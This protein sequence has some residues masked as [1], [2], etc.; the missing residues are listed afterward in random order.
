MAATELKRNYDTKHCIFAIDDEDDIILLPTIVSSGAGDLKLSPPCCQGSIARS[1]DGK[2]YRL[3][4][5]NEWEK[6]SGGS[7]GGGGDEDIEPV[8]FDDIEAL[9]G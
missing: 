4:G 3:N 8:D 1:A 7:G 2:N 9:F 6:Y 5:N